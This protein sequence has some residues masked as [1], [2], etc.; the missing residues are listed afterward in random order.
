MVGKIFKALRH[1]R[2]DPKNDHCHL[3]FT[4]SDNVWVFHGKF[5][6]N[7]PLASDQNQMKRRTDSQRAHKELVKL[8][9]HASFDTIRIMKIKGFPYDKRWL[10]YETS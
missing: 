7:Q 1:K 6:C 2:K 10:Y 9:S 3:N 8:F 4:F 5:D